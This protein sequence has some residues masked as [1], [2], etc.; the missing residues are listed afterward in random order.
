MNTLR[1]A[2]E[3]YLQL[4]HDLGFKLIQAQYWLREFANF[5]EQQQAPYITTERALEW[6]LQPKNAQPTYWAKRLTAIRVF[7]RYHKATDPRTE[8]PPGRVLPYRP[9]HA[10]P[11]PYT[12]EEIDRLMQ[13][14]VALPPTDGLR[15][16]TYSCLIGLLT[17]T[18]LRIGEAMGLTPHDVDLQTGLLSL[19]NNKFGKSRLVPVHDTTGAAL[20]TYV[21]H[22]NHCLGH[23]TPSHFFVSAHGKPLISAT[24]HRTFRGL[25]Q[26][27]GLHGSPGSD[28]PQLHHFRHRFAMRTLLQWYQSGKDVA[29][30][31][32]MLA[33]FLGHTRIADTYWYLLAHPEL[34]KQALNRLEQRWE[35]AS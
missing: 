17:V 12:G 16:K 28:E 35:D 3:Q 23:N 5:M 29:Q 18:G 31:L 2:I 15:G 4:R 33:T 7:A 13:A 27:I 6:A 8:V 10:K 20:S 14:A 9:R 25:C 30:Q 11:Y 22:R 1:E 21:Q 19:H 32:P 34:M 26:Q 24:V